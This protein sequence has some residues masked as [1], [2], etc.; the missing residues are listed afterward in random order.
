MSRTSYAISV[1]ALFLINAVFFIGVASLDAAPKASARTVSVMASHPSG[2]GCVRHVWDDATP[3]AG[4]TK[5][6]TANGSLVELSSN[7]F[8]VQIETPN[9]ER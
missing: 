8:I 1:A 3:V 6:R 4:L 7:W 2:G 5:F 9:P